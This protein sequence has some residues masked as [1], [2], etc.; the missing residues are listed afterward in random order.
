MPFNV[1]I[2]ANPIKYQA[3]AFEVG[4]DYIYTT[5]RARFSQS[6]H[7]LVS[8][9][10]NTCTMVNLNGGDKR[11]CC[12]HLAAEQQPLSTLKAG[13]AKNIET[14]REKMKNIE[15]NITAIIIGGRHSGNQESFDLFNEVANILEEFGIPFSMI[16]GKFDNIKNDNIVVTGDNAGIW[17]ESLKKLKI[18]NGTTGDELEEILKQNYEV[19]EFTPEV[20]VTY[21]D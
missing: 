11:N 18:P 12:M 16:C 4:K 8:F 2:S 9:D 15:E 21:T 10:A 14:L 5:N 1:R 17:N 13:L 3:K 20:S 6:L 19:V 7:P